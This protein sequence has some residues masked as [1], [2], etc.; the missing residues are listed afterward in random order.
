MA[1]AKTI[2]RRVVPP[3]PAVNDHPILN[4]ILL[5]RGVTAAAELDYGLAQLIDPRQLKGIEQAIDLLTQAYVAQKR[6]LIV[7]DFDAD[8]ATS[9]ALAVRGLRALGFKQVDFLVPN[10]FEYGYGLT[11][12]IV[13]VAQ[14]YQPELLITVDN[15][16]SSVAGVEAANALGM[17]VL[18]TDHHL[19][20]DALPPAAAIV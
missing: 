18:I 19:P 5:A 13:A 11:P 6:I 14:Q 16:I 1:S 17:Q 15:G 8:G 2:V 20:G 3:L 9:T 7:G 12:E 10:R 4:R